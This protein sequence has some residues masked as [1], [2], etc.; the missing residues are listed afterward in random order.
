[1]YTWR[2]K[3]KMLTSWVAST[4]LKHISK[5]GSFPRVRVEIQNTQQLKPPPSCDVHG[6]FL[7]IAS[8]SMND[9]K[10]F[11]GELFV[12]PDVQPFQK[13]FAMIWNHPTWNFSA[14]FQFDDIGWFSFECFFISG[15]DIMLVNRIRY[16]PSSIY[17]KDFQCLQLFPTSSP[18]L[19]RVL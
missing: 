11:N 14:T 12:A 10:F 19:R 18:L 15:G 8:N 6:D 2:P 16:K 13:W 4:D 3:K 7:E 17:P 9:W 5:I 1:M